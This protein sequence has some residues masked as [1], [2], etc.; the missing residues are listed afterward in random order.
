MPAAPKAADQ[1]AAGRP[2]EIVPLQQDRRLD[3]GRDRRGRRQVLLDDDEPRPPL[4]D[5]PRDEPRPPHGFREAVARQTVQSGRWQ[6]IALVFRHDFDR[7]P[8]VGGD[9][10]HEKVDGR[11]V[12]GR[13]IH[14]AR[15]DVENP[16]VVPVRP[17]VARQ[18]RPR[19]SVAVRPKAAAMAIKREAHENQ[20]VNTR[21]KECWSPVSGPPTPESYEAKG[22]RTLRLRALAAPLTALRWRAT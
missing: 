3:A 10:G 15:K 20:A 21:G 8:A 17:R 4:A 19:V 7:Q 5:Q 11:S 14:A 1:P 22:L 6:R 18:Y 12:R 9:L 2:H 16:A 13:I